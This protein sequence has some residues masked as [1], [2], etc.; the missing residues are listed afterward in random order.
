MPAAVLQPT[1]D[2]ESVDTGLDNDRRRKLAGHLSRVLADSMLLMIKTQVYHWNVVGPLFKPIH[3]LTEEQYNDLFSATDVIAERIRAL[4]FP[5]PVS[6][7]DLI[8]KTNLVEESDMRSAHDMLTQL[9]DD[10]EQ[11][12]RNIRDSAEFA[13]ES[14]DLVT[15]DLLVQRMAVHEKAIWMLRS[16]IA[17]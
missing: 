9:V 16:M 10:H 11:I 7:T 5:A 14:N 17:D 4:G 12:V 6:F 1:T 8:P 2:V 15:H 3:D 13:E